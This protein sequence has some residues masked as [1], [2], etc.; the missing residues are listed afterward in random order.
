MVTYSNFEEAVAANA[1]GADLVKETCPRCLGS[2]NV[3]YGS[4][5]SHDVTHGCGVTGACF[6]CLGTGIMTVRYQSIKARAKRKAERDAKLA[7]ETAKQTA[8]RAAR[9]DWDAAN[10]EIVALINELADH[11]HQRGLAYDLWNNFNLIPTSAQVEALHKIK[12][13]RDAREAARRPVQTGKQTITGRILSIKDHEN[14]YG[15]T[16]KMTIMDDRGFKVWGTMT[17]PIQNLVYDAWMAT[18]GDDAEQKIRE[19]GPQV[20]RD[21][22]KNA[23]QRVTF[24]ATVDAAQ[25]D[26]SFDFGFFKRPTKPALA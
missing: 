11:D 26:D 16:V 25:G 20:W 21:W 19:S 13:D 22:A 14:M 12:A 5:T 24:T 3:G 17:G 9:L 6:Q 23:G 7:E 1:K 18:F 8:R 4:V 2:G 10:P 15:T